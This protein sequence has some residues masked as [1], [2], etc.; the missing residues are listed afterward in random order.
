MLDASSYNNQYQDIMIIIVLSF[1]ELSSM[2][3]S[4]VVNDLSNNMTSN[5]SIVENSES[6]ISNYYE[7]SNKKYSSIDQFITSNDEQKIH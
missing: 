6:S 5:T 4:N 7:S 3:K 1:L 2:I